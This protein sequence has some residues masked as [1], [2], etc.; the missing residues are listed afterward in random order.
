MKKG[1]LFDLDGTL[2]S[3]P[4]VHV[5]AWKTL[6]KTYQITLTDEELQEQAGNKNV[7]FIKKI[8]TRRKREEVNAQTLSNE[9]DAIVL[10]LLATQ[11]AV[12]LPEV[13][14]LLQS[15]KEQGVKLALVTNATKQTA[16]ILA[17]ELLAYFDV[18]L[19]AEDVT[20]G[21][22]DPEIFLKAASL[23]NLSN[24]ACIVFEDAKEGVE[25]AKNGGF[26]CI[27]RDNNLHQDLSAADTI[28][29]EYNVKEL[30]RLFEEL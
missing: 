22:P 15:L 18:L 23:L 24:K 13:K 19:F 2:I 12:V 29:R 30:L 20:H 5:Q 17:K 8:L 6:F 4:N 16:L 25:A 21:K 14:H 28:V 26:Y 27:A 10:S 3:S 11:P 9:K 1:A 7:T